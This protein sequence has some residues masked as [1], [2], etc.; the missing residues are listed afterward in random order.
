MLTGKEWTDAKQYDLSIDTSKIGIDNSVQLIL[1]Y[2][3]LV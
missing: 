1:Q 3:K 2:L